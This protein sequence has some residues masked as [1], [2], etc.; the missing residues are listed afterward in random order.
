MCPIAFEHGHR[1][2][3]V[4]AGGHDRDGDAGALP[5]EA[6][7]ATVSRRHSGKDDIN[8]SEATPARTGAVP[9]HGDARSRR[10]GTRAT[11]ARQEARVRPGGG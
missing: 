1:R 5:F 2:T 11:Q 6:V 8:R 3:G 4:G 10:A 9:G 7:A